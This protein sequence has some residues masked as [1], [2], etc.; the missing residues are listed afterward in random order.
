MKEGDSVFF[1]HDGKTCIGVI[2]GIVYGS[3]KF[4]YLIS[5]GSNIYLAYSVKLLKPYILLFP[6]CWASCIALSWK[7]LCLLRDYNND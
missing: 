7:Q 3:D 4:Y 5:A 2:S 6:S 1:E